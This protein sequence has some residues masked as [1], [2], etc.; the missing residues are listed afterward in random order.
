MP[1]LDLCTL[2][3]TDAP[4]YLL[5]VI[6][7]P[8]H[9]PGQTRLFARLQNSQTSIALRQ[10][11][12]PAAWRI[13]QGAA[14][15]AGIDDRDSDRTT[16][17]TVAAFMLMRVLADGASLNSAVKELHEHKAFHLA[18]SA[19]WDFWE[20]F[21]P[22]AHLGA[23]FHF[24]RGAWQ[25]G[26]LIEEFLIIA[27]GLR[28]RGEAHVM[29]PQSRRRFLLDPAETYRVPKCVP[30]PNHIFKMPPKGEIRLP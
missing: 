16:G 20:E 22:A 23:A 6:H 24:W 8:R 12:R 19:C 26:K 13:D 3:E 9:L 17:A 5:A 28:Q 14:Q 4:H 2:S 11:L 30:L 10:G 1:V 21:R 15:L 29:P 18:P 7:C 27:E 25:P